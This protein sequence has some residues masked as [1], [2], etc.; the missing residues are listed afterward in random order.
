MI[1]TPKE[2]LTDNTIKEKKC[3]VN[4]LTYIQ[5]YFPLIYQQLIG[6]A[7]WYIYPF[8]KELITNS[9]VLG[10]FAIV[11]LVIIII[12]TLL[13]Y[14]TVFK[15]IKITKQFHC[16]IVHLSYSIFLNLVSIMFHNLYF[17]IPL[18]LHLIYLTLSPIYLVLCLLLFTVDEYYMVILYPVLGFG[19]AAS[20]IWFIFMNIYDVIVVCIITSLIIIYNI[21]ISGIFHTSKD[22]NKNVIFYLAMK[23]NSYF[24][25]PILY[26]FSFFIFLFLGVFAF[27]L[28][29][30]YPC[31]K[32]KK[33]ESNISQENKNILDFE[34]LP[35][36]SQN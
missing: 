27:I 5:M 3:K 23:T 14:G 16:F 26:I 33:D 25:I 7:I 22:E 11:P 21:I 1:D 4:S 2:T 18:P 17:K 20:Y 28:I 29:I 6:L 32:K 8:L 36:E 15:S 35:K 24:C 19:V 12:Q 30:C 13:V 9:I 10:I 31:L 34:N